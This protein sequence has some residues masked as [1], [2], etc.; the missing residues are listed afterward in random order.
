MPNSYQSYLGE[1]SNI[2]K[3]AEG[4]SSKAQGE[5]LVKL[6]NL[7]LKH[8]EEQKKLVEK[9]IERGNEVLESG[10]E[11]LKKLGRCTREPFS[12]TGG[13][14]LGKAREPDINKYGSSWIIRHKVS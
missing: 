14:C 6:A 9:K 10:R 1:K 11:L 7:R 2:E 3:E 8:I 12:D 4:F 5:L 13:E